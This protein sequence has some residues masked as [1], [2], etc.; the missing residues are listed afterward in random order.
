MATPAIKALKRY[1]ETEKLFLVAGLSIKETVEKT[2]L[3]DEVFW[4]NERIIFSGRWW[5]KIFQILKVALRIRKEK[6]DLGFN[7]HRDWRY[8]L[9]L[10]LAGIKQ[11]IGFAGNKNYFLTKKIEISEL[12]HHIFHYCALISTLKLSCI[13]VQMYFPLSEDDLSAAAE[14]FLKPFKIKNFIAIAPGG[15]KNVKEEMESR[16]WP[17]ELIIDLTRLILKKRIQVVLIGS[18]DDQR[19]SAKI[20]KYFPEVIDLCGST[21]ITEAAALL[22]EARLLITGDNGLMHL[23]AAVNTKVLALFGP[24]HPAEK[25]PLAI[26]S[27]YIWKPETCS[28]A[29]CYKNGNFPHCPQ[30]TC[31]YAIRPVEVMEKIEMMTTDDSE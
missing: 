2:N 29:P 21:T 5:Q 30:R 6:I 18:K 8:N 19:I 20:K 25:R 11:R 9:I 17:E 13:D 3:F 16:R 14:K 12:K 23:A 1:A 15:A 22:K 26:F 7:F 31:M 27:S 10:F 4:I 24:T 28:E